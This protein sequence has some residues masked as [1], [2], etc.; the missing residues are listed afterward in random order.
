MSE[1]ISIAS[2]TP[3]TTCVLITAAIPTCSSLG[4]FQAGFEYLFVLKSSNEAGTT[5]HIV[6]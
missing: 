4:S 6:I 1:L 5:W 3:V 2:Q